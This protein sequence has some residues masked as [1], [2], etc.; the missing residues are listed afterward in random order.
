MYPTPR[1]ILLVA[2]GVPFAVLAGLVA[3][4][5]WLVGAAW[6]IFAI[7][8]FLLDIA[9]SADPAKAVVELMMPGAMGVGRPEPATVRLAFAGSDPGQVEIALDADPH[10]SIMPQR[11]TCAVRGGRADA[12][13]TL[14]PMRRGNGIV[15][16][17][18]ARW[19]GPLG[20]CWR[21]IVHPLDRKVSIIP[22]VASVKEDAAK[23]FQ[24]NSGQL[25]L[26]VRLRG[27]DGTE[28]NALRDFQP[29]MDRRN[30]DWKQTARHGQLLVREFEAEENLHIVFA[31]DSGR[32]MCEPVLGVPRI[33]RAIEVSLLLS[34]VALRLGDRV[35]LFSFDE[36]PRIASASVSGPQAFAALQRVAAGIDY[37]SA[38]T[39][40]TLGLTQLASELEHRAVVVVFTDF[41]DTISAELML[42]NISRLLVR[43]IVLFV[44][45]RDEELEAMATHEPVEPADV[46]RAVLADA[47]LRERNRVVLRLKRLGVEVIDVPV[48]RIGMGVIDAYLT[49]K[50]GH[51]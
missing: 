1:M 34:Y 47:M 13:L 14:N 23:L 21:Q 8:L 9:V 29:G 25:G 15:N 39:N 36:K 19:R 6:S 18:W 49:V 3:P 30:I 2:L 38:E 4:T 33:D 20:L 31:L 48:E 7:G 40:F 41:A 43:H 22:N 51:G 16:A 28:F 27:G 17:L 5:L 10:L 32:L 42:D 50:R 12:S 35:R 44:I 46:S 11:Q 45:F 26:R 37:S 24:R